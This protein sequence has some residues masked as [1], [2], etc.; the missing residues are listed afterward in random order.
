[1]PFSRDSFVKI[2]DTKGNYRFGYVMESKQRGSLLIIDLTDEGL[3]KINW[4][5]EYAATRGYETPDFKAMLTDIEKNIIPML[6]KLLTTK[7]I[8]VCLNMSPIT[9][10]AHIR[11]LKIKLRMDTREQLIAYAQGIQQKLE[12]NRKVLVGT[13]KF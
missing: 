3:S 10:R 8:G 5:A 7:E 1:V 2:V 9:V 6:A 4:D 13:A 12:Q 11:D